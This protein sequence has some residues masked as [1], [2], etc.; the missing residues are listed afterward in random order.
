MCVCV[1]ACVCARKFLWQMR[2]YICMMTQVCQVL[3]L[4]GLCFERRVQESKRDKYRLKTR[5]S[6]LI[7]TLLYGQVIVNCLD[8]NR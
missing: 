8:S 4:Q 7:D 2:T 3:G 1:R 6:I 5:M